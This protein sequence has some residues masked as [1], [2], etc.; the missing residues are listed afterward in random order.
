MAEGD[1]TLGKFGERMKKLLPLPASSGR[2]IQ[3]RL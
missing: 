2:P 3:K 1:P